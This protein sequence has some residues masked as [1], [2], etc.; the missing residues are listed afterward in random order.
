M[1]LRCEKMEPAEV[2][3]QEG[4]INTPITKGMCHNHYQRWHRRNRK[5]SASD[6]PC[7]I[8]ECSKVG[9]LRGM[10]R[11]HY[12]K[13]YYDTHTE[14]VLKAVKKYAKKNEERIREW[15]KQWM[16]KHP[17]YQ[18]LWRKKYPERYKEYLQRKKG[19]YKK[20]T[21]LK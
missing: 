8:I 11:N 17:G 14:T 18:N 10:C 1:V 19:Q 20:K 9:I 7:K 13:W 6:V 4:C 15:R 2:C 16:K 12:Q 21:V 3:N 5:S